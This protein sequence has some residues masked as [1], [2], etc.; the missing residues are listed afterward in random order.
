MTETEK[1]IFIGSIDDVSPT[2][3]AQAVQAARAYDP[4]DKESYSVE[5]MVRVPLL[6]T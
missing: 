1:T 3:L 4:I 5:A 2:A 6:P